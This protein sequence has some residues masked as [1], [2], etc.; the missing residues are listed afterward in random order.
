MHI[1]TKGMRFGHLEVL[2][3]QRCS[4][5]VKTLFVCRCDCG[6]EV[7]LRSDHLRRPNRKHCSNQCSLLSGKRILDLAGEKFGRWT[8]L[9]RDGFIHG[10]WSA[11]RCRCECG[12]ERTLA[13]AMLKAGETRSC[14]CLL[15]D[16]RDLGLT[17][18]EMRERKRAQARASNRKNPARIKANKIK[19]ERKLSQATPSWLT[20]EQWAAMNAVYEEARRRTRETGI[21]HQVDHIHPLQGKTLSGLHVPWNLQVLTASQNVAKSNRY[22]ELLGD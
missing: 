12:T 8:V 5:S 14:G 6:K 2:G 18:E 13:G 9:E 15:K 17:P 3:E 20:A 1:I 7:S 19:Y 4:G 22:A 10:G 16:A 11:W 21:V